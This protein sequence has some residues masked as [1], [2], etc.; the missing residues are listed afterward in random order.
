M[1]A[2][3]ALP[4]RMPNAVP[5]AARSPV[6]GPRSA[7]YVRVAMKRGGCRLPC[8]A[9]MAGWRF[10]MRA[11]DAGGQTERA[12]IRYIFFHCCIF[13]L[14]GRKSEKL[15]LRTYDENNQP[16]P[17]TDIQVRSVDDCRKLGHSALFLYCGSER[18]RM[19][20]GGKRQ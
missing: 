10:H 18:R 4:L 15:V 7:C 14:T 9:V 17:G 12:V 6:H 3:C 5:V 20:T 19:Q 13:G 11:T 16:I 2:D 8:P 1:S